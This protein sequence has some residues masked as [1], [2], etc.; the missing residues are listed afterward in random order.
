MPL[1]LIPDETVCEEEAR[2]KDPQ[3][4]FLKSMKKRRKKRS[5]NKLNRPGGKSGRPSKFWE[6][7]PKAE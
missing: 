6:T 4:S 5:N 1:C 7:E 2:Y 3:I